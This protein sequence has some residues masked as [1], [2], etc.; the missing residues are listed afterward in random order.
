MYNTPRGM[1]QSVVF[2][3]AVARR[4][5]GYAVLRRWGAYCIGSLTQ[6]NRNSTVGATER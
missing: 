3:M 2:W 1:L 6:G 5:E 4:D